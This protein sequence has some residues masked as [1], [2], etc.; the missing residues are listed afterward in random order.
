[1]DIPVQDRSSYLK[2]LLIVA[3][4]DNHLVETEKNILKKLALR[5]GFASDFYEETIRSLMSN[6]YIDSDAIKFSDPS[7][8][9]SFILDGLNLAFSDNSVTSNEISWLKDTALLNGMTE[10]WFDKK[11]SEFKKSDSSVGEYALF[12]I[13]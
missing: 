6:K 3:K 8:A 4:K 5:L 1:M 11:L 13:I 12:S 7:I 2:G 9:E 10:E